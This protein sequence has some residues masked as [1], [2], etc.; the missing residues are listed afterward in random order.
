TRKLTVKAHAFSKAAAQKI[1]AA[2]GTAEVIG[3]GF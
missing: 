3:A 1:V 2:G